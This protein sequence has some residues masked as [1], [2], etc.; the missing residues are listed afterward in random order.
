MLKGEYT[1]NAHKEEYS[2]PISA[3]IRHPDIFKFKQMKQ[4]KIEGFPTL[5]THN[6]VDTSKKVS[7]NVEKVN[8]KNNFRKNYTM[9][10]LA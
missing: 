2:R 4:N 1:N 6:N 3:N 7:A 10:I 5:L 9:I 8:K